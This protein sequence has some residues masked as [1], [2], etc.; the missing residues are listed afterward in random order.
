MNRKKSAEWYI[1][2]THWLTSMVSAAII[3]GII[4]FVLAIITQNIVAL[5]IGT[6]VIY[7]LSMWLAVIYSARFVNKRYEITNPSHIVTL[8]TIF[9]IIVAGGY[10]GY[11]A[12][13]TSVSGSALMIANVTGFFIAFIIFYFASK[14]YIQKNT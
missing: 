9:L 7:P 8:S 13:S 1:A 6:L 14:K 5:S 2:G 12:L 11:S 4:L 3:G 10:R